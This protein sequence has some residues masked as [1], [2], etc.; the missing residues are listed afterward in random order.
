MRPQA[1]YVYDSFIKLSA[2]IFQAAGVWQY[3]VYI[4]MLL[5]YTA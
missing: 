2:I 3:S 5:V 1:Q 4:A